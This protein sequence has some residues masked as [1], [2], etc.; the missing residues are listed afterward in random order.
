MEEQ[1]DS[2][3][4]GRGRLDDPIVLIPGEE[5]YTMRIT[6]QAGMNGTSDKSWCKEIGGW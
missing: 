3:S 2:A 4:N 1:R 5:I 6:T